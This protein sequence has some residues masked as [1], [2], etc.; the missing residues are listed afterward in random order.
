MNEGPGPRPSP[1]SVLAGHPPGASAAA[2]AEALERQALGS[3]GRQRDDI[4]I[5]ALRFTGE[6]AAPNAAAREQSAGR[7]SAAAPSPAGHPQARP[8][9]RLGP[10]RPNLLIH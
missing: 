2:L 5:V 4:A 1:E 3:G 6:A 9:R 10:R 8:A 7:G